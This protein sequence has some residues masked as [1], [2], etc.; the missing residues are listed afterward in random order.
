LD[1]ASQVL[2]H[3]FGFGIS[4]LT[5]VWSEPVERGELHV[6]WGLAAA[7]VEAL[8]HTLA[9]IE[10]KADNDHLTIG[11]LGPEPYPVL[12][13]A[14]EPPDFWIRVWRR[15][16]NERKL[17]LSYEA[18]QE[19]VGNGRLPEG[20]VLLRAGDSVLV[21]LPPSDVNSLPGGGFAFWHTGNEPER[22]LLEGTR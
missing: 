22:C 17:Y 12:L 6:R 13:F 11:G 3:A 18:V 8:A 7:A 21:P 2:D 9:A 4:R 20:P 14:R 19:L 16:K 1:V 10:V 5:E 15:Q